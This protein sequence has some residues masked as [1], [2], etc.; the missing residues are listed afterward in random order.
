MADVEQNVSDLAKE[1]KQKDAK[2]LLP[3]IPLIILAPVLVLVALIAVAVP[4]S[5]VLNKASEDTTDLLAGEY[6]RALLANVKVQAEAPARNLVPLVNSL[7]KNPATSETFNSNFTA[8]SLTT[9]SIIPTILS[10]GETYEMSTLTCYSAHWK[11]GYDANTPL[12]N[13][14]YDWMSMV[15]YGVLQYT[16]YTGISFLG[17]TEPGKAE[18]TRPAYPGCAAGTYMNQ[19][20]YFYLNSTSGY[21]SALQY[22]P[23]IGVPKADPFTYNI[24]PKMLSDCMM[25]LGKEPPTPA[26]PEFSIA[27]LQN[28]WKL[29]VVGSRHYAAGATRPDYSC[30]AGFRIDDV[31][32]DLLRALKPP[33]ANSVVALFFQDANFTIAAS[34][35]M[36]VDESQIGGVILFAEA[37]PDA[38]TI[39][40]QGSLK[41]R[42]GDGAAALAAIGDGTSYNTKIDGTEWIINTAVVEMSTRDQDRF[43]VVAAVP[44]S[45]I[46]GVIDSA[47]KRSLGMSI[48]IGVGVAALIATVFVFVTLPLSRLAAQMA[49]LTKLDF[50]TLES[51]GALE[52]RSI[53]WELRKVQTTFATMVRA[54]AGA[55]KKNKQMAGGGAFS[56]TTSVTPK[57]NTSSKLGSSSLALGRK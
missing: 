49:Q 17:V 9:G 44:H 24:E 46:Y 2:S 27:R 30:V 35:N 43:L 16:I 26:I 45:E 18:G 5:V 15:D 31:W 52:R 1:S 54:F 32:N 14:C 7:L 19:T 42:Y 48:G 56:G 23:L 51:S 13:D 47:R 4:S 34:S 20:G 39:S 57:T 33:V 40:I 6:L 41:S 55:I 28:G 38:F 10:L 36:I 12:V 3:P 8:K 37:K 53:I 50:G 11:S 22:K 21:P 29:G 25:I